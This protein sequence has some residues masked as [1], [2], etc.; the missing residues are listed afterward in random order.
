MITPKRNRAEEEL[1]IG[2]SANRT[3]EINLVAE[4]LKK[5]EQEDNLDLSQTIVEDY[6]LG[7]KASKLLLLQSMKLL[8]NYMEDS[9]ETGENSFSIQAKAALI[10]K[11]MKIIKQLLDNPK[12]LAG[13][14]NDL[15]GRDGESNSNI[16]N[17]KEAIIVGGVDDILALKKSE[18]PYKGE[19]VLTE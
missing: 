9:S 3:P 19:L 6:K 15:K 13:I 8:S 14:Y 2:P 10:E 1:G 7:R 12:T 11:I 4:L 16:Y 18:D 17:I 5:V